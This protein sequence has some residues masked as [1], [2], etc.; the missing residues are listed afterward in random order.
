MKKNKETQNLHETP[1]YNVKQSRVDNKKN[2]KNKYKS[3]S[4]TRNDYR[5][6]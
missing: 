2:Q 6:Q 5:Y 1:N 3:K 4:K